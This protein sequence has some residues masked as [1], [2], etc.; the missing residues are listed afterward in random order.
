MGKYT[1]KRSQRCDG[2]NAQEGGSNR[3][4]KSQEKFEEKKVSVW[5]PTGAPGPHWGARTELRIRHVQLA[6]P[7]APHG[8]H[9]AAQIQI[10]EFRVSTSYI[11]FLTPPKSLSKPHLHENKVVML[12]FTQNL[13]NP[14]IPL[15]FP[16]HFTI[17]LPY[18]LLHFHSLFHFHQ[19]SSPSHPISWQPLLG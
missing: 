15:P 3:K 13:S 1:S 4:R 12:G 14:L 10:R 11:S 2:S 9:S 18:F 8:L 6:P 5:R 16:W 7:W 19:P 17:N